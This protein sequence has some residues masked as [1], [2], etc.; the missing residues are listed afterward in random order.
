M[1]YAIAVFPG[2]GVGPELINEGMKVIDKAAELDKF[3]IE[4][5]TYPHGAEHYLETKE[6]LNEKALKGIKDS[7]HAIYCGT[8][9]NSIKEANSISSS[10]ISYFGQFVSLRPVKL[11]PSVE[12]PLAGKTCN[13][14]DFA[15]IRD[16]SEDFYV[17]AAGRAKSGRS[18][19]QLDFSSGAIKAKFGLSIEAKGNEIAYQIGVLSRKG[20]ERIAR[21]AFEYAKR[22]GKKKVSIVDKAN[23]LKFYMFWRE[24]FEAVAKEYSEVGYEFNLVDA[25]AMNFI[26]QPEK[27]EVIAAP[28]MFGDILSNLGAMLQ[29]GISFAARGNINPEGISMFEP[30]HGSATKLKGQGIV[31]PIATIWA[32]ALMLDSVGQQKSGSL[33]LKAIES[34]LRDGKTRTQDLGGS[35]TTSEMGDAIADKLI[36]IHD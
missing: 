29:G 30:I 33:I 35:N 16:N 17:G 21:Y 13:E 9:D 14:I 12:S 2:D 26:R 4:W 31:N 27:Y 32:G 23:M 6:A 7:C 1:K 36:D 11:L 10:I 19:L 5:V 22:N 24:I 15:V 18:R 25:A 20:C 28:G 3:E 8:F 34:V